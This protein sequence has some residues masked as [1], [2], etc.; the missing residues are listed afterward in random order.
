MFVSSPHVEGTLVAHLSLRYLYNFVKFTHTSGS[1]KMM[2][3]AT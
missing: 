2:K 1:L 3:Y